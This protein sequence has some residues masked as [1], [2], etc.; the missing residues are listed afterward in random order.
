MFGKKQ[1]PQPAEKPAE[2]EQNAPPAAQTEAPQ[3]DAAEAP[4][5]QP[6]AQPDAKCSL[7]L[8]DTTI[9]DLPLGHEGPHGSPQPP[10]AASGKKQYSVVS[11]I[12]AHGKDYESGDTIELDA[13]EAAAMPWAVKELD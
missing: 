8:E 1:Q 10:E 3:Q 4:E 13:D 9:C 6:E 2:E 7:L 11:R 5:S 12:G